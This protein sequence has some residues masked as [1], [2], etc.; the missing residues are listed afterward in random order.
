M[1]TRR[2]FEALKTKGLALR[3]YTALLLQGNPGDEVRVSYREIAQLIGS[4]KSSVVKGCSQ[5]EELGLIR[6]TSQSDKSTRTWRIAGG[7][8]IGTDE[9][10]GGVEIGTD[11]GRG[12]RNNTPRGVEIGT[13]VRPTNVYNPINSNSQKWSA[14]KWAVGE[15]LESVQLALDQVQDVLGDKRSQ[16]QDRHVWQCVRGYEKEGDEARC[17]KLRDA[18]FWGEVLRGADWPKP[19]PGIGRAGYGKRI[20]IDVN[21]RLESVAGDSKLRSAAE[22]HL[23]RLRGSF[24]A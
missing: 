23:A 2:A 1:V 10:L 19:P 9:T 16:G 17:A 3:V 18:T 7:V 15:I 5:L 21:K 6:D 20:C 14:P 22:E 11:G 4:S 8:E 12:C 24:G 13:V